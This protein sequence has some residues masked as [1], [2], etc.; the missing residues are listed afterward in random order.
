MTP[1]TFLVNPSNVTAKFDSNWRHLSSRNQ[2]HDGTF[3][4]GNAVVDIFFPKNR[5]RMATRQMVQRITLIIS[6]NE[7][8]F[9]NG[10]SFQRNQMALRRQLCYRIQAFSA[11]LETIIQKVTVYSLHLL[12]IYI[13][14]QANQFK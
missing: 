12:P 3:P 14:F 1:V 6:S 13:N 8:L 2:S 11:E 9:K 4:L 7:L 10:F 5:S